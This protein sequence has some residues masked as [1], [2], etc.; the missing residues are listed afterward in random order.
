MC[1][2]MSPPRLIHKPKSG[3]SQAW[4]GALGPWGEPAATALGCVPVA[5]VKFKNQKSSPLCYFLY[6]LCTGS[7][8]GKF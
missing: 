4:E 2:D 8:P 6:Y 7:Y 5:E 1:C 3:Q